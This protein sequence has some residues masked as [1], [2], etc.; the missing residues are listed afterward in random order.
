MF[1]LSILQTH[2]FFGCSFEMEPSE[3]FA[4]DFFT[5]VVGLD[6]TNQTCD[7]FSRAVWR[8]SDPH[9]SSCETNMR[10]CK[11]ERK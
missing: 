11:K 10:S 2:R 9:V 7:R 5:S 1:S 6:L 4:A 8:P 3:V